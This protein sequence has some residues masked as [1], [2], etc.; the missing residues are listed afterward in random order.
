MKV[1]IYERTLIKILF[2]KYLSIFFTVIATIG[3]SSTHLTVFEENVRPLQVCAS[4]GNGPLLV[5]IRTIDL[6]VTTEGVQ[7]PGMLANNTYCGR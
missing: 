7:Q 5:G 6:E 2:W 4:A 3:F 1:C